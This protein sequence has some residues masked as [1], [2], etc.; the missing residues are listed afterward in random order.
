[1]SY[2]GTQPPWTGQTFS[3]DGSANHSSKYGREVDST[4]K[5]WDTAT[6]AL[7][8]TI[9]P[10]GIDPVVVFSP[11]GNRILSWQ[12]F[13][14][15][16]ELRLWDGRSGSSIAALSG[17]SQ[18]LNSV[19][20]S[21]DGKRVLTTSDDQTARLWES[22]TGALIGILKGHSGPVKK[23]Y[24]SSKA[25][26][27]VTTSRDR[28]A[29]LWD[30]NELTAPR[31]VLK[32]FDAGSVS[33]DW[34]DAFFSPDD[35]IVLTIFNKVAQLWRVPT[36]EPIAT[37]PHTGDRYNG[38]FNP[39]GSRIVTAV[40]STAKLGKAGPGRRS[41]RF[42]VTLAQFTVTSAATAAFS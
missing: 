3:T 24:F 33:N 34:P 30:I 22:S 32:L 41:A 10:E 39:S 26:V 27:I 5:L 2:R 6:G 28:T 19:Q 36:G 4:A 42:L 12:Y 13:S 29:R 23:A 1:M 9:L 37:I 17:H 8:A 25:T 21:P 7:I 15:S 35:S 31:A 18:E 16:G 38:K 14:G 11:D 20:F 40:E